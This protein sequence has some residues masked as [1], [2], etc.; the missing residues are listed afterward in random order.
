MSKFITLIALAGLLAVVAAD[1]PFEVSESI[2]RNTVESKEVDPTIYRLP[3]DLDP[4]HCEVEIT[5]YFED[6]PA[7][8]VNFTFDGTV[9]IT[10]K[11]YIFFC[12][13]LIVC[14]FPRR[15]GYAHR[16]AS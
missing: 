11:V 16:R 8:K 3:E 2:V 10:F 9:T 4:I 15:E 7:G 1:L 12:H 13:T 14:S 5:P 6:A